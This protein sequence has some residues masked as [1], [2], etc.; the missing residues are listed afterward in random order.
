MSQSTIDIV[1]RTRGERELDRLQTQMRRLQGEV[2]RL[3]GRLPAAANGIRQT[4]RAAATA[5]NGVTRLIGALGRLG[6]AY[7][8]VR[9]GQA[10]IQTGIS[11]VES[12]RRIV[13]LARGYGEVAALTEAAETAA[14]RFGVSQTEAN[15]ALATT[16]ARL[17][18]VGVELS[19]IA[20]IYAGFSTAARLSGASA[21][22]AE[23]AFRQL[24]QGLGSGAL[25]GDEFNS[26][27]EQVPGILTAISKETGVA[28]G[29]LR[30][31]AAEGKITA[32]IVIRALKRI[33]EEGADQL[34]EAL[35]GP[36]QKIK[37]FQN[38]TE[39]VQ[40]AL[41]RTIVPEM[42]DSFRDLAG[43]ILALEG[44]IK[45]I[46]GLFA[47]AFGA[48]NDLL[49]LF[50]QGTSGTRR[51]IEAGRLPL[52]NDLGI[53]GR[54]EGSRQL[55][56]ETITPFG[57]GL[58]GL[59]KEAYVA[60]ET[61]GKTYS[62]ALI[63]TMQKYLAASDQA[64]ALD[65]AFAS[66]QG[67]PRPSLP[68]PLRPSS[69]SSKSG[70]SAADVAKEQLKTY[71][72][73]SREFSRQVALLQ[74]QDET[75]RR[76]LE[77][78]YQFLDNQAQINEIQ[79]SSRRLTLEAL[80]ADLKRL[81]VQDALTDAARAY[82]EEKLRGASYD[83]GEVAR[84][85]ELTE[86]AEL[87][88]MA[89]EAVGNSFANSLKSVAD[90]TKTAQEAIADFFRSI[91]SALLNYAATA[92][93]Q[94]IAI[95]IARSFAG[96]SGGSISGQ[97]F[98]GFSGGSSF[99]VDTTGLQGPLTPFADGGIVRQP[100]AALIGEAGPEAVIPLSEMSNMNGDG[101]TTVVN[102]TLNDVGGGSSTGSGPNK[103]EAAK[104]ARMVEA[105]TVGVIQRERR[106]GGLLAR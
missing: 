45:Y 8:A 14:R 3:Q 52:E 5:S 19:D 36:A 84:L 48:A 88:A 26:V 35:D 42:A 47:N 58:E 37:D 44:P 25:R 70:K 49:R 87:A 7:G 78:D 75:S 71:T 27:A 15:E 103:E 105:A 11:R 50:G 62:E 28:Q 92:I 59:K 6:L 12:E 99:G 104:L 97:S 38:A 55:F 61:T 2:A 60:A 91:A 10:A 30:D 65:A 96:L 20:S 41:T 16:Y 106:P 24:A 72:D 79:D 39:E 43:V 66:G 29:D 46:G 17:R 53:F 9:A 98:G 76:L 81:E 89:G 100:T 101:G 73:L 64:T 86:S 57:V 22:E 69:D 67:G 13:F 51:T 56:S 34:S 33:E 32:D 31:Y 77:I 40:V 63:A 85:S 102:I 68:D 94:Y 80:N 54:G 82:N 4:G 74:A 18:P 21:Q 23:G 95:G 93:A 90:G 1:V 83:G